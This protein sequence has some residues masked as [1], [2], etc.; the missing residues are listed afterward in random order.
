M[1]EIKTENWREK[2]KNR[3]DLELKL[4]DAG[5]D[6]I[7]T[8]DETLVIYT[9]SANLQK[10]KTT[11]EGM[12]LVPD[13]AETGY[14]ARQKNKID[15]PA[16]VSGLISTY[17]LLKIGESRIF[18]IYKNPSS[19]TQAAVKK[20]SV[21]FWSMLTLGLLIICIFFWQKIRLT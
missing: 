7:L 20:A 21:P 18:L 4:I 3:E 12:D 11:I 19:H 10:L 5:A 14:I 8:E 16:M 1:A 9:P 6:D 17:G 13:Y 2:I 15:D